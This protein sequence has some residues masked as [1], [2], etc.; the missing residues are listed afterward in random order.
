MFLLPIKANPDLAHM[1]RWAGGQGQALSPRLGNR[2]ELPFCSIWAERGGKGRI[3]PAPCPVSAVPTLSFRYA[4]APIVWLPW[5]PGGPRLATMFWKGVL[6]FFF[7]DGLKHKQSSMVGIRPPGSHRFYPV[8]VI[9]PETAG[10]EGRGGRWA[11][12]CPRSGRAG[13][14]ARC[15]F[16]V[17]M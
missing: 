4:F 17:A 9:S 11:R 13:R 12:M 7:Q 8:F 10:A 6:T 1:T 16:G 2:P 15:L 5:H 14:P 3:S